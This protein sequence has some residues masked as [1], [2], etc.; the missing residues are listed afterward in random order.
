MCLF[1]CFLTGGEGSAPKE[2]KPK[3]PA[4]SAGEK[5]GE[6]IEQKTPEITDLDAEEERGMFCVFGDI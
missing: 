2:S 5:E 3:A 1:T 4:P 6:F